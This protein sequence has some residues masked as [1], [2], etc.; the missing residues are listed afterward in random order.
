[1]KQISSGTIARTLLQ[2]FAYVN[3]VVAVIGS[4][5]FANAMWY[6]ITSL[7]ITIIITLLTY[8]YNNDWTNLAQCTGDIFKMVKDGSISKEELYEFID[9]HKK[10]E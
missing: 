8:W 6:Q 4:T 1:M 3:Q 2:F 7:V 9:N 10:V 5:S